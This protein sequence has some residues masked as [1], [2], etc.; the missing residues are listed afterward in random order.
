ME[1]ASW[2]RKICWSSHFTESE[3]KKKKGKK[4]L[5][6]TSRHWIRNLSRFIRLFHH[7][8]ETKISVR[9]LNHRVNKR[10]HVVYAARQ[11]S[12]GPKSGLWPGRGPKPKS[13]N[14]LTLTAQNHSLTCVKFIFISAN[15]AC[16]D[17]SSERSDRSPMKTTI[18]PEWDWNVDPTSTDPDICSRLPPKLR[19][20]SQDATRKSSICSNTQT[21]RY[22]VRFLQIWHNY[23]NIGDPWLWLWKSAEK[24]TK[25]MK[26]GANSR[27]VKEKVFFWPN[28]SVYQ[29]TVCSTLPSN[30]HS[31]HYSTAC[32]GVNVSSRWLTQNHS[33]V[34]EFPWPDWSR[35]GSGM[36]HD[37]R[38]HQEEEGLHGCLWLLTTDTEAETSQSCADLKH[39][40][41]LW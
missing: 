16:H 5:N 29:Y 14:W 26:L 37:K 36:T 21:L 2:S 31:L 25:L 6:K 12:L 19:Y 35:S 41:P 7:W 9:D 24:W 23:A 8:S 22:D 17:T 20:T 18:K 27:N 3:K 10:V 38:D 32:D 33:E 13:S 40:H 39:V 1:S 28:T 30:G 11:G 4:Y 15:A 34:G